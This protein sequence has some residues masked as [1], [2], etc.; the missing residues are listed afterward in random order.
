MKRKDLWMKAFKG[1]PMRF[2]TLTVRQGHFATPQETA[3]EMVKGWRMLRQYLER[4][5]KIGKITFLAVFEAH[6]SGWP[7]LHILL[8]G[9]FIHHRLIRE[10]WNA[11]FDSFQIDI[12]YVKNK[13]QRANYVSKYVSQ[14]P[15]TFE[16]CRRFWCSQDWDP[17]RKESDIPQGDEFTWWESVTVRPSA[18]FEMAF[19]DG[20][21]CTWE[22]DRLIINGWLPQDR[23]RWGIG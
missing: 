16:G 7:H 6:E 18:I 17:P 15:E 8:R 12:R 4:N 1:D 22:G 20:A 9:R 10:W 11:R 23:M 13:R 19:Y 3:R 21:R 14:A 2:L 5:P